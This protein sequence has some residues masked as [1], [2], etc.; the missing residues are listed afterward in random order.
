[1]IEK[2]NSIN[3]QE[4]ADLFSTENEDEKFNFGRGFFISENIFNENFHS[5]FKNT[6]STYP[7]QVTTNDTIVDLDKEDDKND[8]FLDIYRTNEVKEDDDNSDNRTISDTKDKVEVFENKNDNIEM[9]KKKSGRKPKIF[10]EKKND[11]L[12]HSKYA[13]DNILRKIKVMFHQFIV[14]FLNGCIHYEWS[15]PQQHLI[16]KLDGRK[17]QN[18]T[19]LHN[20]KLLYSSI[21]DTLSM[22]MS[23]KYKNITKEENVKNIEFLI[24]ASPSLK[25]IL[26]MKYIVAFQELFVNSNT[27]ILEEKYRSILTSSPTLNNHMK[28]KIGN[29]NDMKYWTK[30]EEI[31]R[32]QFLNH[33]LHTKL[34]KSRINNKNQIESEI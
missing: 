11:E 29:E 1:M 25:S 24:Q 3:T 32:N 13:F 20:K 7:T 33:F 12:S 28:D 26:E 18:I 10:K 30:L 27:S 5:V 22:F 19:L 4:I 31:A 23:E 34:R 8:S 6:I 14:H 9:L 2:L 17:T 15:N 16:K 21:K